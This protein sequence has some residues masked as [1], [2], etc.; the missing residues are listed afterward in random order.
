MPGLREI[1]SVEKNLE[2]L[3]RLMAEAEHEL[4]SFRQYDDLRVQNAVLY[5]AVK[6]LLRVTSGL[7][8]TL[9]EMDR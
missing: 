9:E 7:Y 8:V 1:V 4:Q 3:D 2:T 5:H 6:T